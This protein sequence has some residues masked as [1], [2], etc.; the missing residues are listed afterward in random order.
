L[1]KSGKDT[2]SLAD[3]KDNFR[4]LEGGIDSRINQADFLLFEVCV[5]KL[6]PVKLFLKLME[7]V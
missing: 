3:N 2:K 6:F 7:I 5:R 1:L 4:K